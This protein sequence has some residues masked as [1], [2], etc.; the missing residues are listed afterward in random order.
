MKITKQQLKELIKEELETVLNEKTWAPTP[1][2]GWE[3]EQDR[4]R[5]WKDTAIRAPGE[6]PA[7][8]LPGIVIA[9]DPAGQE[10]ETDFAALKV[11]Q[12][13]AKGV[14]PEEGGMEPSI[15]MADPRLT[16]D[17]SGVQ[18]DRTVTTKVLD[19][20]TNK[21]RIDPTTGKGMT[22][23]KTATHWGKDRGRASGVDADTTVSQYWPHQRPGTVIDVG[24]NP[25]GYGD[26]YRMAS[27]QPVDVGAAMVPQ[28]TNKEGKP[29]GAEPFDQMI[30]QATS[31]ARGAEP[32]ERGG[33]AA[34][35]PQDI[36]IMGA[37]GSNLAKMRVGDQATQATRIADMDQRGASWGDHFH[38]ELQPGWGS[39]ES[40]WA[41]AKRGEREIDA[42]RAAFE[43]NPEAGAEFD[44][45][46]AQAA[47]R[48]EGGIIRR[49]AGAPEEPPAVASAARPRIRPDAG[50]EAGDPG[51]QVAQRRRGITVKP[52]DTMAAMA[53]RANV[54][55]RAFMDA[56]PDVNPRKIEPD[57]VL[58]LP[59]GKRDDDEGI[60]KP[61]QNLAEAWGF[62][63]DLSKL[64]E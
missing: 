28:R 23:T 59:V 17:T 55:L 32:D 36:N 45:A 34:P 53:K 20:V 24:D 47:A 10:K 52:R 5:N 49:G 62:N 7:S 63:M 40:R 31:R 19:P 37:H 39:K 54:D 15:P 48:P 18:K 60:P 27:D 58:N 4:E 33:L 3:A 21:Q 56:N 38:D 43:A 30:A 25:T 6:K 51:A 46:I 14:A 8:S 12:A 44:A 57:Q 9:G 1:P 41:T 11:P 13:L 50:W 26:Y 61:G 2:K 29:I 16:R 42:R 22:K 64:N 35:Q